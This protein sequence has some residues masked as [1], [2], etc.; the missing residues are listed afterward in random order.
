MSKP[1]MKINIFLVKASDGRLTGLLMSKLSM[2]TK[3]MLVSKLAMTDEF[4]GVKPP[5]MIKVCWCQS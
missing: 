2:K 4:A 5:T 1:A 3:S